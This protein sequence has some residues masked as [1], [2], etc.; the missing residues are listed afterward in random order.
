MWRYPRVVAHRGGGRL[1]PENTL[2]ALRCG[3]AHGFHAVEFDVT[4]V[5]NAGLVL[6]HD[7]HLGR[8]V[9]G[10]GK[11]ADFTEAQLANMD[12][13]VWFGPEFAGEPV[14][15]FSAA[16]EFC[17]RNQIWMNV[18]IKPAV[19]ADAHTGRLVGAAC[20]DLPA[21]A[22]LLS[23]FSRAALLAAKHV[24]PAVPRALLVE[25]FCRIGQ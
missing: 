22:V 7:L 12:A 9:A 21:G 17:L 20:A 10:G 1:A 18:E 24:A 15:S 19:G 11:V 2:A 16:V 6:M 8:T 3:L 4:A 25:G 23:S 13:G 5:R 14:P